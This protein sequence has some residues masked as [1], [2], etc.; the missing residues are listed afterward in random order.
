[1]MNCRGFCIGFKSQCVPLS[2][3]RQRRWI[4]IPQIT[5]K[6]LLGMKEVLTL[7]GID[8]EIGVSCEYLFD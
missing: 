3:S 5:S 2:F 4:V 6:I 1:M 8:K 7:R